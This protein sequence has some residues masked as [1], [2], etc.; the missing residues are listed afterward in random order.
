MTEIDT[1]AP[2]IKKRNAFFVLA[3]LT[4]GIGLIAALILR[5]DLS[6]LLESIASV[7][8]LYLTL[9][10]VIPHLMIGISTL[11]WQLFLR[12]L[13]LHLGFVRLFAIY[14]MGTF[15]NNF[16]P[17]MVGGDAIRIYALGRDAQDASSV[18]AATFLER[19]V[20]LAALVSLV[21]LVVLSKTVTDRF[22]AVWLVA[23]TCIVGFGIAT[24][25]ILSSRMDCIMPRS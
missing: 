8:L 16:L 7:D 10:L 6:A 24:A 17:T 9:M 25:L 12:E 20:G 22:P 11:K 1:N 5:V 4:V 3:K 14:L 21:P 19:L 23:A 2:E 18:M 15:F 13:G